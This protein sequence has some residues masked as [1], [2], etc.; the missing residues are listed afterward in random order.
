MVIYSIFTVKT[1]DK[2]Y[3]F[4]R[5]CSQLKRTHRAVYCLT[6]FPAIN[7]K[8]KWYRK[9]FCLSQLQSLGG[10]LQYDWLECKWM[11]EHVH[12]TG[13]VRIFVHL[14]VCVAPPIIVEW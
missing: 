3:K 1:I 7:S 2:N 8:V 12:S 10:D 11:D 14:H 6:L 9:K 4:D 5:L 13:K